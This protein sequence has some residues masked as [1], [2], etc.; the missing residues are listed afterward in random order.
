MCGAG[1]L[2]WHIPLTSLACFVFCRPTPHNASGSLL[3]LQ[4]V[5]DWLDARFVML[6]MCPRYSREYCWLAMMVCAPLTS[7]LCIFRQTPPMHLVP[8]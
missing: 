5:S 8:S 2:C 7:L 3:I 1:L 4:L 6:V